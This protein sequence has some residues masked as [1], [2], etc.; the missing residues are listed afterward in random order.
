MYLNMVKFLPPP[1][2]KKK[3]KRKKER[4]KKKNAFLK[5]L[6]FKTIHKAFRKKIFIKLYNRALARISGCPIPFHPVALCTKNIHVDIRVSKISNRVS[7]RHPDTLW[8]C[9]INK[10]HYRIQMLLF[11]F[12]IY[13]SVTLALNWQEV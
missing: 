9:S 2:K 5:I 11:F 10:T 12:N 1:K 3:K 13:Q 7:K 8:L 4:K 6:M